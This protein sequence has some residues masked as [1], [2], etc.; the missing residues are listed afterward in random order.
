LTFQ[1]VLKKLWK[2]SSILKQLALKKHFG[3]SQKKEKIDGTINTEYQQISN[4]V[5]KKRRKRH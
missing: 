1:T 3:C 5:A 4:S 2:I